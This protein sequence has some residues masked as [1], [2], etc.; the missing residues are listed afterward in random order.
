MPSNDVAALIA[1]AG[2]GERLGLGAKAFVELDG[3]SL[4]DWAID[5]LAG[6]VDE[7]VVAVAAEHVE[8]VRGA[9]RTVRVIAG[10]ATRQATVASLVRATSCRIVLVHDAARPFL[11]AAT[12]RACLAAAR[13]HGAASVAMRVA[14]TLIDA[15]SGAVVERERLRAVQTPQAFLRT[16][17]LA[18]HAAAERDGAEATDDAGLVRRSGRRVA[19][20]EGGAHLFKITDPTDLE[21]ARAYAASS[22]AAA[23]RRAGAP[24][25]GVLRARAPAKLNLGLRIV[26]RRSDGFH[27]VETTMVTLDLHDELTLRVAGADDVL[28]S[29]RSGDPAIDRAP[30]PLGPENLVRRAI[31]AYR[32]AA[33]ETSTISV[34]PLA[35]RLRKHV[36]LASGL[37]GGS[38]DAAATLRLLARTWPA[39]L[40]LH[41]IASAIGSDVPFFLRGGWARATGRGER[42]DP[43]DQQALTAVLVN[44]GVGVSAADAY[45]WWSAAGDRS[46]ADGE[47][48]RGFDLRNDLEPGVA[49]HVPAVRELLEWLR[50]V[51]PG[52]VAMS[53]SGA[54]CYAIVADEAAAQAL[55]ERARSD[56]GWWARVVHDA[57][58]DDLS[59]PW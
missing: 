42:L 5:A 55:A 29:L 21:L 58:P 28:E 35:G 33:S 4:V 53:G 57:P 52:P 49:A 3:R 6:E 38:S 37:G 9:H 51:A 50:S 19:L 10:G 47:P 20:V 12:V 22:T 11:D 48:W 26:G 45:A 40:D 14:D 56:R 1:A 46:A 8:R 24:T 27:E 7:V 25:D 41:T 16:V 30:L 54:T 36:P 32:R 23:A 18:A 15:E 39:G 59:R 2:L 43:L 44:P 17:L 34:P 31:D 13:A